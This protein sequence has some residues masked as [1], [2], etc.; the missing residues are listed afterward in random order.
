MAAD[1]N[2]AAGLALLPKLLPQETLQQWM[3]NMDP[4]PPELAED[5]GMCQEAKHWTAFATSFE[6][7]D[8]KGKLKVLDAHLLKKS[9]LC[10]LGVTILPVDIAVFVAVRDRVVNE[11]IPNGQDEYLN[12][13]RWFDYIQGESKVASFFQTVPIKKA[14]FEPQDFSD[15]PA[16]K[17]AQMDPKVDKTDSTPSSSSVPA[18]RSSSSVPATSEVAQQQSQSKAKMG[19]NVTE[20]NTADIS[21]KVKDSKEK[22]PDTNSSKK[23]DKK[24]KLDKA[25]VSKE[26]K[27]G[28]GEVSISV[29]DIRIGLI[30]K[31]WK[32]PSA[33]A[34]FVEEIDMGEGNVRQVVSGLARYLKEEDL[35][36]RKVAV[37]A[38]VKPGKLRDVL[39]SGLVLCASSL[40]H[41]IVEPLLVPDGA[42]IGERITFAGHEGKPE[43]VLNPKKKQLE[44]VF[45]DL[46]TDDNGVATYQGIPFMTSGG[47]CKSSLVKAS[48]K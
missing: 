40:D 14:K 19:E 48:I 23:E 32:H 39:S 30:V 13:V 25:S 11:V 46:C 21:T 22:V 44:K 31:V 9:V 15:V 37:I 47:P 12:V 8:T 33:D 2:G 3:G 6:E 4:L 5:A 27:K 29:L 18:T 34:L 43:E 35:L 36:S 38:N 17:P 45:P 20:G 7:G 16:K 42:A 1:S 24:V 26:E 10:G 28:E 41:S